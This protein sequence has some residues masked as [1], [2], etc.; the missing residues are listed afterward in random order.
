MKRQSQRECRS[1]FNRYVSNHVDP[2]LPK[3]YGPSLKN[4]RQ[5]HVGASTL[6]HQGETYVDAT[7]KANLF[8]YYFSSVFTNKDVTNI[9]TLGTEA[10]PSNYSTN[11][12]SCRWY[13][14]V[15]GMC[16]L[17]FHTCRHY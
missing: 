6:K 12:D 15:S 17:C 1:A 2:L 9:F 10:T 5:D 7:D 8:A 3:V 4:K 13:P 11:S 16:T 14:M